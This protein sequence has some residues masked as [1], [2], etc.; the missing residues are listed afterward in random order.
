M[1]IQRFSNGGFVLHR[2]VNVVDGVR[3]S[4]WYAPG[5]TL[6]NAEYLA[7]ERAWPV[8]QRHTKVIQRLQQLGAVWQQR[9]ATDTLAQ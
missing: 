5:G 7:G 6:L 3:I 8:Q 1:Q 4:A 2:I 9:A